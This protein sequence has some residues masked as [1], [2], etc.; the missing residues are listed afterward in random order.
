MFNSN[1]IIIIILI[2]IVVLVI[3]ISK[4][5]NTLTESWIQSHNIY[6]QKDCDNIL[7]NSTIMKHRI[8]GDIACLRRGGVCNNNNLV[9]GP[10]QMWGPTGLIMNN[11]GLVNNRDVID[12]KGVICGDIKNWVCY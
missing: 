5:N 2:L 8:Y 9:Y 1:E 12:N 7:P 3:V 4:S 10:G 11:D 6:S